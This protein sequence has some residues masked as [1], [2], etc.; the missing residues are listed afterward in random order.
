MI[1]PNFENSTNLLNNLENIEHTSE[2]V[3]T[4]ASSKKTPKNN[5]V[6]ASHAREKDNAEVISTQGLEQTNAEAKNQLT[7]HRRSSTLF[8]KGKLNSPLVEL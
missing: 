5:K 1:S 8:Q 7:P 2:S 4:P 6:L 3:L